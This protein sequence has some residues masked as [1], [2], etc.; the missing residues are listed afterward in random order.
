[1]HQIMCNMAHF[2]NLKVKVKATWQLWPQVTPGQGH[3]LISV[4]HVAYHPMRLDEKH[5]LTPV[6]CLY[7]L[8]IKSYRKKRIK[9]RH[10]NVMVIMTSSF[11][12]GWP[13]SVIQKWQDTVGS[14]PDVYWTF[15]VT[16]APQ[17]GVITRQQIRG[18]VTPFYGSINKC[19]WT[20]GGSQG[21]L[22]S[23]ALCSWIYTESCVCHSA[24]RN[25]AFFRRSIWSLANFPVLTY[26]T[27]QVWNGTGSRRYFFGNIKTLTIERELFGLSNDII[28]MVL[29]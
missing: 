20:E 29:K 6:S 14:I 1:M 2:W 22:I 15:G 21:Q 5:I 4:G 12:L 8:P 9:R 7:L 13:F 24:R 18:R 19:L 3:I 27:S 23:V 28:F 26:K 16:A 25:D 17:T 10:V 11:D